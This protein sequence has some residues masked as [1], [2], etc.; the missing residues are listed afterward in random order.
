[1]TGF[2]ASFFPSRQIAASLSEEAVFPF[3]NG[4]G[5]VVIPKGFNQ[6]CMWDEVKETCYVKHEH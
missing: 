3:D 6:V 1:M 4:E 5:D 2:S